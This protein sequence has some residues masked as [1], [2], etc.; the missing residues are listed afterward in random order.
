MKGFMGADKLQEACWSN[1]ADSG[2]G[3]RG[4]IMLGALHTAL[5]AENIAQSTQMDVL[6]G[7]QS[8][9]QECLSSSQLLR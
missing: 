3:C 1:G 5:R 2:S 7:A 6:N 8:S 4:W 9:V